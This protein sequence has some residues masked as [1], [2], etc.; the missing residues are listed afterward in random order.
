LRVTNPRLDKTLEHRGAWHKIA[1]T[2]GV[3][4]SR[5]VPSRVR[6]CIK[7]VLYMLLQVASQSG[8]VYH[9]FPFCFTD[10]DHLIWIR[11]WH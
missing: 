7:S 10:H 6:R 2:R 4:Y 1:R 5:V 3:P 9:I 8:N 11:G